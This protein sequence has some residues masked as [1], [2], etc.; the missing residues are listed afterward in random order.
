QSAMSYFSG[1]PPA[2]PPGNGSARKSTTNAS[3]R[4]ATPANFPRVEGG[5]QRERDD[6]RKRVLT[7]ELATEV[8]LMVESEAMLKM[9]STPMSDETP[10]SLKYLDRAAKLKQN[11]D[12]HSRNV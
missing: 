9:G 3:A 10:T 1:P 2:N 12:S 6:V 5:V 4:T 11:V 8:R 7:E